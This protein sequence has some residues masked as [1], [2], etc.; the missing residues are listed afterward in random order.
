MLRNIMA[1]SQN[2]IQNDVSPDV[3]EFLALLL[4]PRCEIPIS[5][6]LANLPSSA[7]GSE[8]KADIFVASYVFKIISIESI[9]SFSTEIVVK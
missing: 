9:Y 4:N 8:R 1:I 3:S 7:V 2:F 6:D 5:D